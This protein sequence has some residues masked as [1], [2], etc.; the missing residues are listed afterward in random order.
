MSPIKLSI[1]I[2]FCTIM[3]SPALSASA[4]VKCPDGHTISAS[5]GTNGGTCTSTPG[6]AKGITC[7]DGGNKGNVWCDGSFASTGSGSTSARKNAGAGTTNPKT[8]TNVGTIKNTGN[9]SVPVQIGGVKAPG[10]G[11]SVS[12]SGGVQKTR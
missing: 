4:S 1:P 10:S 12:P 5:T 3:C 7:T 8:G 9:N 11:V 2:L 6:A